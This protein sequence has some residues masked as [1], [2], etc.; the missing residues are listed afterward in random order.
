M[1]GGRR[2]KDRRDSFNLGL[3]VI[4]EPETQVLGDGFVADEPP[5]SGETDVRYKT[6]STAGFLVM[7]SFSF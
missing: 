5:P 7:L 3:G 6:K 4:W 1:I 2:S